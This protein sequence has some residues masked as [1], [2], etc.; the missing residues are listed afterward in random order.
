MDIHRP[1]QDLILHQFRRVRADL[2]DLLDGARPAELDR[3]VLPGTN[4]TGWLAW[5]IARGQD[6]NLSEL[7]GVEQLWVAQGW[8]EQFGRAADPADT[9]FGHSAEAA[10]AFR[11]PSVELLLAYHGAAHALAERY[12]RTAPDDDLHRAVTSPTLGNTHTV[13][14]R[15]TGQLHDSVAHTGQI[16]LLL[17]R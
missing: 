15:L 9:G 16:G 10:A 1:W 5:H 14:E 8:A 11:S 7:V 2:L 3:Q 6:R 4:S 12:L 13:A 17:G